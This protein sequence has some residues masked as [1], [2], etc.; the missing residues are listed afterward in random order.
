MIERIAE[1][2]RDK[3]IEGISDIRDESDRD[4]VRVV[5]ELK[6]D[7]M[8]EVVLNQLYP[9]HA[10]ADLFGVNVLALNGGRPEMLQLKQILEAFIAFREEVIDRRTVYELRKARERAHILVGLAIAVANIDEVIEMIRARQDPAAARERL[11]G[12]ALA[13]GR[14]GAAVTADRRAGP[15]R[16][17]GRHLPAVR[18]AGPRD[19]RSAPAAPDRAR[20]RQ[21]RRG[22]A[23]RSATAIAR[24]SRH[25]GLARAACSRSCAASC[26]R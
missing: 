23:T 21:D 8:A 2:V 4:G 10:A 13:G 24:L 17:C 12:D 7:A 15:R 3:S 9:L 1:L 6:R 16:R 11:D 22:A 18:G 5:I 25:P 14:R 19:P 20:A 26:S